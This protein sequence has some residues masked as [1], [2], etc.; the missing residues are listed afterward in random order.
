[1]K[2]SKTFLFYF[3]TKSF[4]GRSPTVSLGRDPT[5]DNTS[6]LYGYETFHVL[7]SQIFMTKKRF[8]SVSRETDSEEITTVPKVNTLVLKSEE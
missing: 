8:D 5:V 4:R 3:S 2:H 7:S 1:M 6:H